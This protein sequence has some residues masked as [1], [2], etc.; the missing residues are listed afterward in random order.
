MANA[1]KEL[2]KKVHRCC[3][4]SYQTTR[5]SNFNDHK[6]IHLAPGERQIFVC[7]HCDKTYT[8]KQRL[9]H[10]L[11]N[12]H[13]DSRAK[14]LKESQK[15]IYRCCTCSYQTTYK[16][17]FN[18]HKK[19]HL[20]PGERQM[21]ACLHCDKTYTRKQLLQLHLQNNKIDSRAKALKKSHKKVYRCS[22]CS[23]QTPYKSHL[24]THKNTH[25][26]PEERQRFACLHC[27]KTYIQKQGLQWHLK[28]HHT[29]L[30]NADDCTSV[31][32]EVILDSLK[33]EI[34]DHTPLNDEFKNT[35]CLIATNEL[36]SEDLLKLEPDDVAPIQHKDLQDDFKNGENLSVAK[37]VKLE[38]FIKME[39]DNND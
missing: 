23:Y 13:I 38:D 31:T 39:P 5:K 20:A 22:M 25:L 6:K 10:H 4:C 24:N 29:D 16:F 36:K 34:D 15:K 14:A 9:Q 33:I 30:R 26:P 3:T 11:Q 19:I 18:N 21:F 35:E 12:N 27:N 1:L 28:Y 7:L 37:K 17:N 8:R 2:Q 32:D